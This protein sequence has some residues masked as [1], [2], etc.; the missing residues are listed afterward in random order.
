MLWSGAGFRQDDKNIGQCLSRLRDQSFS[1]L[2]VSIPTNL[3]THDDITAM[4]DQP[5]RVA[6]A[7][8]PSGGLQ[9][10]EGTVAHAHLLVL[11]GSFIGELTHLLPMLPLPGH[12]LA[13]SNRNGLTRD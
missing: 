7:P 10:I 3:P 5:V 11:S 12:D 9:Y 6:F 4:A 13:A 2:L 8:L 1:K